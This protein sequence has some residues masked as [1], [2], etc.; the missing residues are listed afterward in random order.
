M[1]LFFTLG[2]FL[3]YD[4]LK[5]KGKFIIEYEKISINTDSIKSVLKTVLQVNEK[6]KVEKIITLR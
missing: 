1:V 6:E 4:D 5:K 3:V 2:Y